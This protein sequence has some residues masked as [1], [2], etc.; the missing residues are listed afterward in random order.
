MHFAANRV[1]PNTLRH[2]L[3][4]CLGLW[5]EFNRADRDFWLDERPDVDGPPAWDAAGFSLSLGATVMPELGNYDYDSLMNYGSISVRTGACVLRWL[6]LLG[7]RFERRGLDRFPQDSARA[8]R[9][10]P[11]G[12]GGAVEDQVSARDKSRVL[13]YLAR[14]VQPNWGFFESLNT[15]PGWYDFDGQPDPYLAPRV[16]AIG[17][18]A[19]AFRF[20]GH[21][22]V[23][24]RGSDRRL[25]WK[26]F[27]HQLLPPRDVVSAWIPLGCCFPSDPA[28]ISR[29]GGQ[30]DIVAIHA[31]GRPVRNHFDFANGAWQG[32]AFIGSGAPDGQL[33][34]VGGGDFIGPAITSRAAEGLDVFVVLADGRLAVTTLWLGLW[35]NWQTLG[36]GYGVTARPAAIAT[37]A[38]VVRLAVNEREVNLYEPS[39]IFGFPRVVG[40]EL[41]GITAQTAPFAAPGLT[42]RADTV[43]PYRVLTVTRDQRIAHK[44]AGGRW[45]DIGGIPA[46]GTGISAAGAGAYGALMVINGEDVTGCGRTCL[47]GQP[48]PGGVIQ[49]GGVW[50][51]EFR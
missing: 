33:R 22:D 4:H 1:D 3:G 13:Q 48:N 29:G 47:D 31:T 36:N 41:G 15:R 20:N 9:V 27:R 17:T 30:I 26:A 49:P 46:P 14:E 50:L 6:D 23:F 32:W 28:A 8:C 10:F 38:H 2:E 44:L 21:F 5:H 16:R 42:P 43:A 51:R 39:V 24:A 40:F 25:Y 19:I 12:A 37:S 11:P 45:R 34:R 7:N 18:P 35:Q